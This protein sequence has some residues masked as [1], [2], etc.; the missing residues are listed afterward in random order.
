L[1]QKLF[2]TRDTRVLDQYDKYLKTWFYQ[3][4]SLKHERSTR[5]ATGIGISPLTRKVN[6]DQAK[7]DLSLIERFEL[8]QEKV[9]QQE[10]LN[11]AINPNELQ[12]GS[13]QF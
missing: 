3:S 8:Y 6:I 2:I 13:S 7:N 11:I 5:L 4:N 12:Y 1:N 9:N 10:I